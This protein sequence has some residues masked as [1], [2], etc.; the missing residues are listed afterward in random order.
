MS[1]QYI[2]DGY[3]VIRHPEFP[4]SHPKKSASYLALFQYIRL[5]RLC[6]SLKNRV[7][8]VLDGYPD[9]QDADS[10]NRP[11]EVVFSCDETADEKIKQLV[12]RSVQ[13]R[14]IVVV[15]DDRQIRE[16]VGA[17]GA[18]VLK[19]VEFISPKRVTLD[20]KEEATKPE[21]TSEEVSFINLEL[22]K[23]WLKQ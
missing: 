17:K 12:E 2:I 8:I 20:K 19:V 22:Q 16:A 14:N 13:P 9:R 18:K 5:K 15:S 10:V 6:G 1:L 11:G 23:R 3:N 7:I 4:V 21:L